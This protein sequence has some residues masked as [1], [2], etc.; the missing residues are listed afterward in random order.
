[1]KNY[2]AL[3]AHHVD[4]DLLEEIRSSANKEMAFGHDRFKDEIEVL[5]GRRLKPK[6]WVGLSDGVRKGMALKMY[7]NQVILSCS[8][9]D[10]TSETDSKK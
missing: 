6:R 3:F 2:R 10:D 9:A 5:T 8:V 1:M 7:L 4:G